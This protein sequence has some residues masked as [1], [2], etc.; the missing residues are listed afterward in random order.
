M[1]YIIT[2][3]LLFSITPVFAEDITDAIEL[4]NDG[5]YKKA[6]KMLLK[7]D[8]SAKVLN[9]LGRVSYIQGDIKKSINYY[10][11]A[12]EN[13]NDTMEA[14]IRLNLG[15]SLSDIGYL[16]YAIQEFERS[17]DIAKR[18][19]KNSTYVACL[20]NMGVCYSDKGNDSLALT[21]FKEALPL[22]SDK[23]IRSKLYNNIAVIYEVVYK[24]YDKALDLYMKSLDICKKIDIENEKAIA[25][26]NVG[27]CY[28]IQDSL[29]QARSYLDSASM[30]NNCS[31]KYDLLTKFLDKL[32]IKEYEQIIKF[33]YM[34]AA[35][36]GLFVLMSVFLFMFLFVYRKLRWNRKQVKIV[37]DHLSSI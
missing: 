22:T 18:I 29:D 19:G 27:S 34:L 37:L 12:L 14:V 26:S 3:I 9:A 7:M 17:M 13:C 15:N 21:L 11:K 6:E 5:D 31:F 20:L 1:K 24:D 4:Y 30:L 2:L 32:K 8:Q 10:K 33:H 36:I 23:Q 35:I 16:D 28:L 25:Y